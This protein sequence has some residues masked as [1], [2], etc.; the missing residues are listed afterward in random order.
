MATE[1]FNFRQNFTWILLSDPAA[2][3][4]DFAYYRNNN[5]DA[6]QINSVTLHLGTGSGYF[7]NNYNNGPGN[8]QPFSIYLTI[9]GKNSSTVSVTNVL[10]A[11]DDGTEAYPI[12]GNAIAY[13]FTFNDP[14]VVASGSTVAIIWHTSGSGTILCKNYDYHTLV[15]SPVGYKVTF[16]LA[17]GTR[18][19]G[20]ELVQTVQPGGNAIPPTC[21]KPGYTFAGW[22]GSYTN[23]TSNRTIT[24]LWEGDEYTV[25]YDGNGSRVTNVPAS[26][27][28]EHGVALTLSSQKPKKTVRVT[29]NPMGGSV[30]PT[31]A[32]REQTF[33]GW[34]TNRNGPVVYQPGAQ[35]TNNSSVTLYAIWGAATVGSAPTPTKGD[36]EFLGWWT[37]PEGGTEVRSYYAFSNDI[38]IYAHWSVTVVFDANGGTLDIGDGV[39]RTRYEVK[40]Q[41]NNPVPIPKSY[42]CYKEKDDPDSSFYWEFKGW[43]TSK[44]ATS[45][46]YLPGSQY[47]GDVSV[48]LYAVYTGPTYTVTFEDGYSGAVLKT[49]RVQ[50][51]GDATPPPNPTRSGYRFYGWIGN[52][53][54][55]MADSTVRALWEIAFIW[56]MS[57]EGWIPY[58]PTDGEANG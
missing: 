46:Q 5:S 56:I 19:G 27:T 58:K 1:N 39:D 31:Y 13:T 4:R 52:Y 43:S 57:S 8:G 44:T 21:T 40:K 53:T 25:R 3:P 47:T 54:N 36:E 38:T 55:V 28:K 35:Y 9:G 23:V 41:G 16:D 7:Y 45:P 50:Y 24:A 33:Q 2:N 18:T 34:G 15:T 17:G 51:G 6:V 49:E 12:R 42:V 10:P 32:D 48:T 14:P 29:F 11:Y 22:D 26:Q 20:G 30:S 37:E